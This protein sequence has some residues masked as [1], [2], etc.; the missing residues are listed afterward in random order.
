MKG[1]IVCVTAA[2]KV[3]YSRELTI[4]GPCCIAAGT[5]FIVAGFTYKYFMTTGKWRKQKKREDEAA[6]LQHLITSVYCST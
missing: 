2:S 3:D 6:R 5:V 1:L 4:A